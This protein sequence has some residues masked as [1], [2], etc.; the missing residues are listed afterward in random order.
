MSCSSA[1]IRNKPWLKLDLNSTTD[2][3]KMGMRTPDGLY[4]FDGQIETLFATPELLPGDLTVNALSRS[5]DGNGQL[6]FLTTTVTPHYSSHIATGLLMF[7][8]NSGLFLD[9]DQALEGRDTG[10]GLLRSA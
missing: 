8:I 1:A 6:V 5:G 3:I 9:P 7:T 10:S 4:W 2:S